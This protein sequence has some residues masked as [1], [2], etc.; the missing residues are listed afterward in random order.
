MTGSGTRQRPARRL[1]VAPMAGRRFAVP[2][3]GAHVRRVFDERCRG[4]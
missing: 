3:A 2:M 1:I 4:R